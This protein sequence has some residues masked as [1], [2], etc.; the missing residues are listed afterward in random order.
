[1]GSRFTEDKHRMAVVMKELARRGISFLDSKTTPHSAGPEQAGRFGVK[2]TMRNVF[3]DNK[4]DFNYI[5]GQLRQTEEIARSKG[6]AV[7]I[8][9]PKAQTYLALKAWLPTVKGKGL[10]LVHLSEL[11][12]HINP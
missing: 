6:Y 11:S 2:L 5:S 4:D 8:G 3:L 12:K 10:R 9:H 7:A 1:M